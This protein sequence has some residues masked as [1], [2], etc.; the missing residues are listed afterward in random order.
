[1]WGHTYDWRTAERDWS[2]GWGGADG[3]WHAVVLPR[4][5][6]LLPARSVVEIGCGH[7]RWTAFLRNR[8]DAVRAVDVAEPCVEACRARFADD[9]RVTVARTDGHHLDGVANR[10]VDLV[11]SFDSLVHADLGVMDA[12]LG[13]AAR[14]LDR[15]GAAFLHHSN[16]AECRTRPRLRRVPV[17]RRALAR[18]GVIE[19][20]L[21][22][23]DGTVGA[24]AVRRAAERHG[25]RC[26]TQE[27]IP[28]GTGRLPIDCISTVVRIG[29]AR[30][31]GHCRVVANPHFGADAQALAAL[32]EGRAADGAEGHDGPDAG[33]R[34][35]GSAGA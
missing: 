3:E 11:F 16:L 26:V 7:G 32:A 8:A 22:W 34:G 23:R 13:E 29:S 30:D 28:W 18:A 20:D 2:S 5:H 6:D 35:P 31:H 27:L 33:A 12:Y 19:T 17:L 10:S 14:V 1:M 9:E 25:L 4:I 15:D 24:D 21:H